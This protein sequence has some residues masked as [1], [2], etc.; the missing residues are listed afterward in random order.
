MDYTDSYLGEAD[1]FGDVV[2]CA[3]YERTFHDINLFV[4]TDNDNGHITVGF[5]D[6]F[7]Q[8]K[9][10]RLSDLIPTKC[11]V[12]EDDIILIE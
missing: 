9:T 1:I 11:Q 3:E 7:Y 4:S 10:T 5:T 12:H 2:T 8:N 6:T